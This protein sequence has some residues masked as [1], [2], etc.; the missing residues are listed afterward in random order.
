LNDS[1]AL[2]KEERNYLKPI[3]EKQCYSFAVASV[4]NLEIDRINILQASFKA[5]HLAINQLASIPEL[6]LVD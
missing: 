2:T 5:M 6:L 4:T 1:K 3:I